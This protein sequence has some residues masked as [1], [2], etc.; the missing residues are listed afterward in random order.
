MKKP[1]NHSLLLKEVSIPEIPK[2]RMGEHPFRV[3]LVRARPSLAFKRPV[4][5]LVG[6]NGTGKSTLLESIAVAAGSVAVGGHSLDRDESLGQARALANYLRLSWAKKTRK[7]FFLRSEDFFNFAKRVREE[8]AELR[9]MADEFGAKYKGYGRMLA[10]GAALGQSQALKAQYGEDLDANSH[11]ESFLRLFQS[12][13]TPGGLYILD[14]PEAP[15]SPVRQ[16]ALIAMIQDCVK[17]GSQFLIA[18]H[19]PILMAFP[20]AQILNIEGDSI[21]PKPFSEL[22][23]VKVTKAFLN[24]PDSFLRHL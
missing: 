19:S 23:H 21:S 2:D 6:E 9:S 18:T 3:P 15:L 17:D 14:E 7:G 8:Q 10:M 4:T 20:E 5:I 1:E 12:R 11:G 16:I 24:N 13:L 22:E